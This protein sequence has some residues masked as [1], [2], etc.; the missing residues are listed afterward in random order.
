LKAE[1][2]KLPSGPGGKYDVVYTK[3]KLEMTKVQKV[4]EKMNESREI[5][6]LLKGMRGLF[7]EEMQ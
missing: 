2:T 6:T 7:V 5:A 1:E 3:P 4:V